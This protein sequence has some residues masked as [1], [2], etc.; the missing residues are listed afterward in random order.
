MATPI[1]NAAEAVYLKVRRLQCA[2]EAFPEEVMRSM[3]NFYKKPIEAKGDEW[4]AV[5]GSVR[6]IGGDSFRRF[7]PMIEKAAHDADLARCYRR[8]GH[9]F[10]D[11]AYHHHQATAEDVIKYANKIA[12]KYPSCSWAM[13]MCCAMFVQKLEEYGAPA[14]V[15]TK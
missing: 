11:F 3:K 12:G 9:P 5:K 4:R 6:F 15:L 8:A 7:L 1:Q 10:D 13:A 14:P 2:A